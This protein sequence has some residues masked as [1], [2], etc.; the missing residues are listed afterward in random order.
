MHSQNPPNSKDD[1]EPTAPPMQSELD[2]NQLSEFSQQLQTVMDFILAR[3][4]TKNSL[5]INKN[6]KTKH[7]KEPKKSLKPIV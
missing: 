1:I 6:Q 5:S 2:K 7:I 3:Q 4:V